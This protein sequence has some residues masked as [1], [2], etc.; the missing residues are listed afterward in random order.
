MKSFHISRYALSV[1]LAV[2]LPAGCSGRAASGD[3]SGTGGGGGG[4]GGG[5]YG[6]GR[7]RIRSGRNQ[8]GWRWWRV[9]VRRAER[10]PRPGSAG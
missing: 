3:G 8:R 2:V 1:G 4:A 7:W 9:R 10:D 6:G 5:Y